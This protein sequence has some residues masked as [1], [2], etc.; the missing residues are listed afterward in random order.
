MITF[1]QIANFGGKFIDYKMGFIG[2]FVMAAVIFWINYT[3]SDEIRG[4]IT[5]ALKQG[6]YTFLL[7]GSFM[8]GCE[9][10]AI[11]IK[12]PALAI[13]SSVFIPSAITLLLTYNVHKLKGT[14]KPFESTLPTTVIIPATA[15]WGYKKRKQSVQ[16]YH[17]DEQS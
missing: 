15:F 4:A 8:K 1:K 13:V 14:P 9:V 10:L 17:I 5:A 3:T 11:R 6:G 16:N 12:N 7:G 2:A